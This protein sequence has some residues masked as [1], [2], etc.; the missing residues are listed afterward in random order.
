MITLVQEQ[1]EIIVKQESKQLVLEQ[2]FNN[3]TV[4]QEAKQIV[5]QQEQFQIIVKGG[6]IVA[7]ILPF[8]VTATVNGQTVFTIQYA[9]KTIICFFIMGTGQNP[10][11]GDYTVNGN[12]ITLGSSAPIIQAGDVIFGSGQL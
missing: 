12:V 2:E 11:V 3:I 8:S 1:P 5:L 4:K 9:F 6:S 10:V 7:T